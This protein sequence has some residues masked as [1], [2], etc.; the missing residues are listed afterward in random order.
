MGKHI[1]DAES[2]WRVCNISPDMCIVGG[3]IVPYD[4]Y[5]EL[6]PEKSSYSSDVHARGAK[7]L[8]V[9]SGCVQK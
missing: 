2:I 4:I 7:A 9:G 6:T 3:Q 5:Q 8:H 1:A